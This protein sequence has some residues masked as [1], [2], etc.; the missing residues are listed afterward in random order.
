[1]APALEVGLA[2]EIGSLEVGKRADLL[3]LEDEGAIGR[4]MCGGYWHT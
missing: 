2:D 3:I 4:V 1:M